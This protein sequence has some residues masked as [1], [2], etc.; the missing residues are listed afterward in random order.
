MSVSIALDLRN[1]SQDPLEIA[2]SG[3]ELTESDEKSRMEALHVARIADLEIQWRLMCRAFR[4]AKFLQVDI[5]NVYCPH[6]CHRY[7]QEAAAAIAH[8]ITRKSIPGTLEI[9]GTKSSWERTVVKEELAKRLV[10]ANFSQGH[11][12]VIRFRSLKCHQYC[13]SLHQKRFEHNLEDEEIDVDTLM[14]LQQ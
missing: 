7:I 13:L 14:R 4:Q 5:T 9:L 10:Y 8:A 3:A 12:G 2:D 6:G 1:I 11:H